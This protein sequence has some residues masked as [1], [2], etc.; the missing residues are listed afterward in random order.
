M[1]DILYD[2]TEEQIKAVRCPD[3]GGRIYYS[4][5]FS[6]AFFTIGCKNCGIM[7]R[8]HKSPVP[9]CAKYFGE[10]YDWNDVEE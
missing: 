9:N 1:D 3:C 6:C 5:S 7:S 8:A 2:G 4:F 10:R